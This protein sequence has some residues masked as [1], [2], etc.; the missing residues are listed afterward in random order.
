MQT[1]QDSRIAIGRMDNTTR[2]YVANRHRREQCLIKPVERIWEA[3]LILSV[4]SSIQV[5]FFAW[6]MMIIFSVVR[7]G[8]LPQ[9][10]EYLLARTLAD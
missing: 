6:R 8:K 5:S 1:K 10:C 2:R 9:S 3:V 4:L 7:C